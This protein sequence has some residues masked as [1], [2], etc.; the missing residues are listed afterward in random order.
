[1]GATIGYI[2]G[3]YTKWPGFQD[4]PSGM[5]ALDTEQGGA[6]LGCII[7]AAGICELVW[8]QDPS[9]EPGNLG[10]PAGFL[11]TG[12][13]AY[14][15]EM[16]NA[17]LAHCRLAMSGII[18]TFCYEYGGYN[19]ESQWGADFPPAWKGALGFGLA[20]F[21]LINLGGTS[22]YIADDSTTPGGKLAQLE[23]AK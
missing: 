4:V 23:A 20:I 1:M 19:V 2:F 18:T 7:L 21:A 14:T 3:T 16:R 5:G 10:D 17:E 13:G 12:A 6:G 15:T 11:L 22:F 8:K 9:K